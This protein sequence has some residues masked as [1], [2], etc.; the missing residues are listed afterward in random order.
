M[1]SEAAS[2]TEA[3]GSSAVNQARRRRLALL[4]HDPLASGL[5]AIAHSAHVP[6]AWPVCYK[7]WKDAIEQLRL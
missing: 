7:A 3:T 2:D 1:S 4:E 6:S 5:H